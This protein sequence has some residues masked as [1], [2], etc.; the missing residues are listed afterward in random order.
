MTKEADNDFTKTQ[1]I[2]ASL[3]D[4]R[5]NV[6][7]MREE[8]RDVRKEVS[9]HRTF[10][11]EQVSYFMSKY[12]TLNNKQISQEKKCLENHSVKL[13]SDN[14]IGGKWLRGSG[15]LG[16]AAYCLIAVLATVVMLTWGPTAFVQ[17]AKWIGK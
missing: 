3:I 16:V 12:D 7:V 2:K 14:E 17:I 10:V 15:P 6:S 11:N 8:L 4:I 9:S 5:D 1:L 13:K